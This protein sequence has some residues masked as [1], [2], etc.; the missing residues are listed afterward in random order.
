MRTLLG[1]KARRDL[2]RQR[3]QAGAV[4]ATVFLGIVLFVADLDASLNLSTSYAS[5]YERTAMADVWITGGD[6]PAI[7]DALAADPRVATVEDRVHAD[8]PLRLAGREL[9]GRV[10]G[11][12]SGVNRLHL[13]AGRDLGPDDTRAVVL[14]RHA[15]DEFD[16][17]VG[18]TVEVRLG[19]SWTP[20]PVVGVAASPEYLFPSRSRTDIFTLPSEFAVVFA[21]DELAR[22]MAPDTPRQVVARFVDGTDTDAALA[23]VRALADAHGAGEVYGLDEQPSNLALQSDVQGFASISVLFPLL[24]LSVAG[25]AAYVMLGRLVRRER[26]EI[27]TLYAN[28]IDRRSIVR[29]YVTHGLVI[30]VAGG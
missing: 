19:D 6:T 12:T 14:E 11:A 26:H 29:H 20:V 18:D 8:V 25:M 16:L 13:V 4:A 30:C 1:R 21:P 22:R 2:R 15:A 5:F 10:D 24:F 17:A 7:A 3:A 23:D 27:G 28:G 9:Y